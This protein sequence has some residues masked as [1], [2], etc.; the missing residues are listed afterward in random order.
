[1]ADTYAPS[2]S[3]REINEYLETV[4]ATLTSHK[5]L[6]KQWGGP[7]PFGFGTA[8]ARIG[9]VRARFSEPFRVA[10]VGE[11]KAGKSTLVNALLGMPDFLPEGVVAVTGAVTEIWYG[12]DPF[13]EVFD[14]DGVTVFRGTPK[15][16]VRFSDQNTEEGRRLAG[17]GGRVVARID[18]PVLENLVIIDTPGLGFSARD[19][20]ATLDSLHLAD[21]AILV[22]SALQPGGEDSV[23]L[24]DRLR[25][26]R[27][28]LITVVAGIDRVTE[29]EATVA[30]VKSVFAGVSEGD[31]I[32]VNSR[33]ILTL[34]AQAETAKLHGDRDAEAAA[35]TGLETNGYLP[36][37][38]R[39]DETFFAGSTS[40]SRTDRAL[41]DAAA[42]LRRLELQAAQRAGQTAEAAAELKGQLSRAEQTVETVLRPKIPY[43]DGKID[44]IVDLNVREYI[45][46]LSEA[47]GAYLD[48]LY[49]DRL[50][51]G[52]AGLWSQRTEREKERYR[53]RLEEDFKSLFPDEQ[54]DLT[55][56]QIQRAAD[57]LLE[58]E[59]ASI[60]SALQRAEVSA[61]DSGS[62]GKQL[63]DQAAR[64]AAAMSTQL[65]A[66]IVAL[67]VPGGVLLDAAVLVG[68]IGTVAHF[69]SARKAPRKLALLKQNAK[70]RLR[71]ERRSLS[72]KLADHFRALN[73]ATADEVIGRVRTGNAD[74]AEQARTLADLADAWTRAVGDLRRLAE[75][76]NPATGGMA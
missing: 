73:R 48:Q 76:Q 47:T 7:T 42:V 50:W 28:R 35:L 51:V 57:A 66:M 33:A 64:T 29:R 61:F 11:F 1:M 38:D 3:Q 22:V 60:G 62:L 21:A 44:E 16:A 72:N 49:H 40:G 30:V 71:N 56:R 31:P 69:Q 55:V 5:A 10:V 70:V 15:Q 14:A 74:L 43:I 8:L 67:L 54:L 13:G 37:R 9:E 34:L 2:Q 53:R 36:L 75:A 63:A 24:A 68:R 4:S 58:H 39:L 27:R 46:D 59:W 12:K 65:L 26:A 19:D 45:E 52:F 17:R 41:A 23:D 18:N 25:G 6:D 32:P 20:K